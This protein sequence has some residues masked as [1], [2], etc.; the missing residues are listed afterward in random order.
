MLEIVPN[1]LF[2]VLKLNKVEK[3][4]IEKKFNL[5]SQ[6]SN[7]TLTNVYLLKIE[8]FTLYFDFFLQSIK[9][10]R[11]EIGERFF[12][13]LYLFCCFSFSLNNCIWCVVPLTEFQ[14]NSFPENWSVSRQSLFYFKIYPAVFNLFL[15][16]SVSLNIC[17]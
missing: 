5:L 6:A 13:S 8:K 16:F 4:S 12:Y 1:M 10:I 9:Q 15:S 3:A 17:L 2:W 14:N 11:C 7:V